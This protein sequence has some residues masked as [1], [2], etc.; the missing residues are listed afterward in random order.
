MFFVCV[1]GGDKRIF[2]LLL[3]LPV[4]ARF[5][6]ATSTGLNTLCVQSAQYWTRSSEIAFLRTVLVWLSTCIP[7]Q[8]NIF[9]T[10]QKRNL[11]Y[12]AFCTHSVARPLRSSYTMRTEYAISDAFV[13][14]CVFAYCASV[15]Q[16]M[17][18]LSAEHCF[19]L[20]NNAISDESVLD[21]ALSTHSVFRP[22]QSFNWQRPAKNS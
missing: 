11:G 12:C 20:R 16:Y 19:R 1:F 14:D 17:Y 15:A 7:Y 22:L 3:H 21:C 4:M 5:V 2:F 10:T 9:Q 6:L 18:S 8:L 13:R